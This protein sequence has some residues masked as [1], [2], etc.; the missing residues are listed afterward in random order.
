MKQF[1]SNIGIGQGA[2]IEVKFMTADGNPAPEAEGPPTA[3]GGKG[4]MLSVYNA[5]DK[6]VGEVKISPIPGKVFDHQGVRVTLTGRILS[7]SDKS[8]F[9]AVAKEIEPPGQLRS[10]GAF[11]FEFENTD[12]R[13]E[14]YAGSQ[15]QLLYF[16]RVTVPQ[17]V[18]KTDRKFFFLVR[19]YE[20]HDA[21]PRAPIKMEVGIEDCLHLEFEYLRDRFHL[22][23]VV[24]GRIHFLLVRIRLKHMELEVRR[25]E[26]VGGGASAHCHTETVARYEIMDGAPVKG[27]SIPIRLF[28]APYG[29]T[30][31]YA[32]VN[33]KFN[34]KYFLNLVLVDEE[35]RRYF[36]Q[37]EIVLFRANPSAATQ[38]GAQPPPVP[39]HP[40]QPVPRDVA[41]ASG[42]V[43]AIPA[44]GGAGEASSDAAAAMRAP[45]P[46][47]SPMGSAHPPDGSK[48]SAA[49]TAPQGFEGGAPPVP[50]PVPVQPPG[51]GGWGSAE[52]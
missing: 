6:V 5:G 41:A 36:K 43:T 19:R 3:K 34:V 47:A 44:D 18:G 27:E 24:V 37:Q 10:P 32:D 8:D 25:R 12:M 35:D 31:S 2:R 17:R 20:G 38:Q 52:G 4:E 21:A 13:Y 11:P 22:S 51:E 45:P 49:G 14:S 50:A 28:L 9:M 26:T 16:V 48:A 40:V 30:P 33:K 7:G 39:Q 42:P 1:F 15:V 46:S 29:L 23:D